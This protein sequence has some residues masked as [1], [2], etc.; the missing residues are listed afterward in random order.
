MLDAAETQRLSNLYEQLRLTLL[1][2]SKKNRMLNYRL[3]ARSKRYLQ[4]I[5][6]QGVESIPHR[7]IA[8]DT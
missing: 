6:G 2:L 3:G 1:D 5:S 4:I 7:P 8:A